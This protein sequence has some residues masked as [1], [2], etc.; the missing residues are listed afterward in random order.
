MALR[1]ATPPPSST[2][3]RHC[4]TVWNWRQPI[5]LL[6]PPPHPRTDGVTYRHHSVGK[7]EGEGKQKVTGV[8]G[9]IHWL[10]LPGQ[11]CDYCNDAVSILCH[12]KHC[13]EKIT[14]LRKKAQ[15]PQSAR[16]PRPGQLNMNEVLWH[17]W[18]QDFTKEGH[19]KTIHDCLHD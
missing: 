6:S 13:K 18:I 17:W 1:Q 9:V 16:V 19:R 15:G 2:P 4:M 11:P 12:S 14:T 5:L 7:P 3:A 8:M 10:V